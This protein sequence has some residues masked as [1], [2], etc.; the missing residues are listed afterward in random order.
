[1]ERIVIAIC[2]KV[3]GTEDL[4]LLDNFFEVGGDSLSAVQVVL[5]LRERLD[6][7][8]TVETLIQ[9]PI[10]GCFAQELD[11][12]L[13]VPPAILQPVDVAYVTAPGAA[14]HGVRS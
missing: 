6:R 11:A 1:M 3:L 14:A 5:R 13:L 4:G 12:G 9:S 10:L 8:I 2:R 7:P